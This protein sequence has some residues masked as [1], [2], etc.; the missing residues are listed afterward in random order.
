MPKKEE[1]KIEYQKY[2]V[3]DTKGDTLNKPEL[4]HNL[5]KNDFSPIQEQLHIIILN[6]N[7]KD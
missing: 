1:Y 6:I 4:V 7:I 5:M 2:E 3:C